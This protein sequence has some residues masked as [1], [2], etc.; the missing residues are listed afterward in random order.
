LVFTL[1]F[2]EPIGFT[3]LALRSI[4]LLQGGTRVVTPVHSSE[5]HL[6]VFVL[7]GLQCLFGV[8]LLVLAVLEVGLA[9]FLHQVQVVFAVRAE[10][11]FFNLLSL[12]SQLVRHLASVKLGSV[13]TFIVSR[14]PVF[15]LVEGH[16]PRRLLQVLESHVFER[17]AR[18]IQR[19]LVTLRIIGCASVENEFLELTLATSIAA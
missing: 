13:Q 18:L 6:F 11:F 16:V 17:A 1:L 4:L 3:C 9:S 5:H 10:N 14:F 12:A 15:E 8:R 7:L 2:V 19:H